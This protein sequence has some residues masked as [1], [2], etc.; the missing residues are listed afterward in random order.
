MKKLVE[1]LNEKCNNLIRMH[2]CV[3]NFLIFIYPYVQGQQEKENPAVRIWNVNMD[4]IAHRRME[5]NL[6]IPHF[7][8]KLSQG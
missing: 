2:L 3:F 8:E 7:V 4:L 1:I 6:E 5:E